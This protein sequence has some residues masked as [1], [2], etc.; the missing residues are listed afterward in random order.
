MGGSDTHQF[1]QFGSVMNTFANI[2]N[3]VDELKSAIAQGEY[4]IHVSP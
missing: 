4:D 2:C 3:T 1:L